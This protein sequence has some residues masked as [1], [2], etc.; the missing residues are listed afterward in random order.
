MTSTL[1]PFVECA[2]IVVG[3]S[4]AGAYTSLLI[5]DHELN[6]L[7]FI[8]RVPWILQQPTRYDYYQNE[9]N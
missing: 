6:V 3:V 4:I 9:R 2:Y 7:Q 1:A 5:D 8:W